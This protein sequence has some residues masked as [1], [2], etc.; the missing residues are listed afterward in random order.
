MSTGHWSLERWMSVLTFIAVVLIGTFGLGVNWAR[1]T[2]TDAKVDALRAVLPLDYVRKDV[3]DAQRA[4][5]TEALERLT[6][7]ID[8]LN[9]QEASS[10]PAFGR[11]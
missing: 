1:T 9:A 7:A 6:Q 8:R 10:S 5:L 11:K 4:A 2:A 3:Y